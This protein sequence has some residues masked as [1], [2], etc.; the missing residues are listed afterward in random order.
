[1][2][3]NTK[4]AYLGPQGTYSHLAL[5]K[6]KHGDNGIPC[7]SIPE[8]ITK[9]INAEVAHGL[10]PLE[11]IIQG[12]VTESWDLLLQNRGKINIGK[13]IVLDINHALGMLPEHFLAIGGSLE[14]IPAVYSRD[15]A[16]Q[17]CLRFLTSHVAQATIHQIESTTA[18][19]E[20]IR[21]KNITAAVIAAKETLSQSGLVIVAENIADQKDNKTRFALVTQGDAESLY[22]SKSDLSCPPGDYVTSIAINPQKDRQGILYDMLQ[23]ISAQHKVNML[24]IHSRPD[25]AGG[26]VFFLDLEGHYNSREIAGCLNELKNYCKKLTGDIAEITLLGCYQR[27]EFKPIPFKSIGIVGGN[28]MMGRWFKNF[29]LGLGFSI[30]VIDRESS[31][32]Y[33][34]FCAQ[35]DVILLSIPMTQVSEVLANLRPHLRPGQLLVENCSIKSCSLP[36]LQD[37]LLDGVELLGI[38]TMFKGDIDSLKGENIVITRTNNSS[39]M[40]YAL[41]DLF[42]KHGAN[43]VHAGIDEHDKGTAF[44]QGLVNLVLLLISDVMVRNF[45]RYDQAVMFNT[46]ISRQVLALIKRSL[47]QNDEL[48]RDLQF[49]NSHSPAIR[50]EFL[51]VAR[52][53]IDAIDK[54]DSNKLSECINRSRVFFAD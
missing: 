41:E 37:S 18:A 22:L 2:T 49:L 35:V 5:I 28:G 23:V 26:F 38:H 30:L 8:I 9:V 29:F 45:D 27:E 13:S 1:M 15:Q 52:E 25:A 4:I 3:D 21:N 10:I 31:I 39:K 16:L 47:G 11:N 14:N 6:I 51:R 12:L 24:S 54:K 17:Q 40:A 48:I 53:I 44:T 32:S 46:K 20:L 36:L 7:R 42:Y 34:E 43:I 33:A 19:I 50:A